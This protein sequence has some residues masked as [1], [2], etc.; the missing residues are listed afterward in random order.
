MCG[1]ICCNVIITNCVEH[2]RC[3]QEL[4]EVCMREVEQEQGLKGRVGCCRE[5]ALVG[6][7]GGARAQQVGSIGSAVK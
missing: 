3:K 6:E 5:M 7:L 1:A 4:K 2:G